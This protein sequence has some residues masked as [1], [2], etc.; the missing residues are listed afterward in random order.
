MLVSMTT[1]SDL[2]VDLAQQPL[3]SVLLDLSTG[4]MVAANDG[5]CDLFRTGLIGQPLHSI[6][7][8]APAQMLVFLEAALHFGR[9]V[10]QTLDYSAADGRALHLQTYGT[11]ITQRHILLSFLDL[12]AQEKRSEQA[13]QEAHQREGLTRWQHIYGFFREMEAQNQLILDAAGEGIYG[14]NAEGKATFVN[15]SAQEM[16]GWDA[17]D[18]IGRNLH[19]IIHHRHLNG[20]CFPANECPIYDSFR[21]EKTVRVDDDAFWRK[22]GKPILVE[23]V[24][25]PIYDHG[26]LAG[27]VVIF[28]DVTDRKE[29]EKKLRQALEEVESLRVQLE[30]ENDYLLTEIRSA[31]SHSGIIGTSAS[32]R[33][34]KI[35]ID[36]VADTKTNVL[37]SGPPGSGKSLAV[38]AIH[39]ASGRNKRP[40]VRVNCSDV[41]LRE[42]EAEVFGS[43]RGAT[44]HASRDTTG[45]LI[46]AHNGTLH[47]DEVSDMP[48]E[49]QVKLLSV[50]NDR[51]FR[52]LGDTVDTPV[53]VTIVSTTTRDLAA[54]VQAGRFRQ[55]LYFALCVFPIRCDPLKDRPE[56]VPYLAKHFLDC[57]TTRLGLPPTQLTK[58]NIDALQSY[59]WPGNV[60]ELASIVERAAILAQGGKLQFAFETLPQTA[61]TG[62]QHLLTQEELRQIE[63]EN[64]IRCLRRSNGK[65]SGQSGAARLL[66]L[67]PSTVYSKIKAMSVEAADWKE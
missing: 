15:R 31:R 56:D 14:I 21:H 53:D 4:E 5:A 55:D 24:S 1:D 35:Q 9:Y 47:L 38:S 20:E 46:L 19:S 26:V 45:K 63:R 13:M 22:D 30:R 51:K 43:R 25:T 32:V 62:S 8:T 12:D 44:R 11:K 66:G 18:L 58:G 50:I 42:L 59:D 7:T 16:L 57:T 33:N 27:A 60:R 39:D 48:K 23:Y 10:D 3:P 49:F 36:L 17:E 40:L 6:M 34:L 54:E 52:R 41:S 61:S 28:R 29:S 64:L 2:C 37:V 67:A 65:V